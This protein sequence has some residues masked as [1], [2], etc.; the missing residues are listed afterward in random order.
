MN[1]KQFFY[2]KLNWQHIVLIVLIVI[3][4]YFL[5]KNLSKW[6]KSMLEK[7]KMNQKDKQLEEELKKPGNEPTYM[8][9]EY[10]N[11]ANVLENAMKGLGT[12]E[13]AIYQI[14]K[15]MRTV[16]DIAELEKAFGIRRWSPTGDK[17]DNK[18]FGH[19]F[20]LVG[21]LQKELTDSEIAKINQIFMSKNINYQY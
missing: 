9:R 18:I 2:E 21:W 19:D 13:E 12:D 16:G 11:F 8:L 5:T 15:K 17:I 10:L 7:L 3:A 1:A 6:T 20:D 4:L 14:Y